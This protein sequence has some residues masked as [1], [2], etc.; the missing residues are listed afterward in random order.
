MDKKIQEFFKYQE[1]HIREHST[2]SSLTTD[3]LLKT[4]MTTA[5]FCPFNRTIWCFD[6]HEMPVESFAHHS[7]V[8][9]LLP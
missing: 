9:G 2:V 4:K 8:Y 7:V 6:L 1:E 3:C 5:I